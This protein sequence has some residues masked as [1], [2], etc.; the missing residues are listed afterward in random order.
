MRSTKNR[1]STAQVAWKNRNPKAVWA[2]VALKSGLYRGLLKRRP[3]EIC[4]K[5]ETDAHHP[6]YDRPL[7]VRWLCRKHHIDTHAKNGAGRNG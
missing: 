2:Q 1:K 6:D 4:G 7:F 5:P 3:C